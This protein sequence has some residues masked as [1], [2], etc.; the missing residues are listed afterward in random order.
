MLVP[1]FGLTHYKDV[2]SFGILSPNIW[3]QIVR[4][5]MTPD[6]HGASRFLYEDF[7]T[8][9][10][11]E[12]VSSNAATYIGDSGGWT[13]YEDTGGTIA[14]IATDANGVVALT[15][16]GD[17]DQENWLQH[18]SATSVNAVISDTA[19]SDKFLAWECRFKTSALV[20]N[21]FVGLAEEGLAAAD[22]ITD[23]GAMADKD[24][25]GFYALEGAPT[26]LKFGYNLSGQTDVAVATV[27]TLEA[28]T[29]YNVGFVYDP[30]AVAGERIKVYVDNVEDAD[31]RVTATAIATSTGSAFPD[32]QE[33][34]T[35]LG[36]KNVT[37][38][39]VLS[40]DGVALYQHR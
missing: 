40:V 29:W 11:A 21:L 26:A 30:D 18:G 16:D 5:A 32:G 31:A 28:N 23:A 25:I 33:M 19:G 17:D 1:G 35:L 24:Y 37:D 7:N 38:V 34:S 8:F 36:H 4:S 15:T 20:G 27:Q 9:A 3:A 6:G 13:S 12:A 22:T 39:T 10:I 2:S 14:Q